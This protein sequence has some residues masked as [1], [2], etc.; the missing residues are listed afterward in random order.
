MKGLFLSPKF[1]FLTTI[2]VILSIQRCVMAQDLVAS[3]CKA[4]P[5]VQLCLSTLRSNPKSA[6]SDVGGLSI[7]MVDAT[8]AK[9]TRTLQQIKTLKGSTPQL[10]KAIDACTFAYK[11]ILEVDIPEAYEALP[12][13]PK[14]GE[15]GMS[16][17][18]VEAQTCANSLKL[19][20]SP[21]T[22]LNQAVHDLSA[23]ATSIIRMLL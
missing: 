14:F 11:M 13:N 6:H 12:G 10:Q 23:V 1:T 3:T 21:A 8:K 20:N 18:V 17:C 16:D 5:H 9:A 2:F 7:L 4:T 15:D 19:F 22:G